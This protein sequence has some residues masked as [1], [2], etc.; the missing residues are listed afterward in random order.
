MPPD[1]QEERH[2]G[3]GGGAAGASDARR[4]LP[5]RRR[6]WL[7]LRTP[8]RAPALSRNLR[9]AIL[10]PRPL[11]DAA[12]AGFGN[13]AVASGARSGPARSPPPPPFKGEG[14]GG[15]HHRDVPVRGKEGLH[16]R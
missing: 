14:W 16:S 12:L 7:V 9:A 10:P 3:H 13:G 5:L 15:M 6:L 4:L 2:A 8:L 11:E 1:I